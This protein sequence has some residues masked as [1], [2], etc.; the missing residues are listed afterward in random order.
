M[1]IKYPR[2]S[3]H[4]PIINEWIDRNMTELINQNEIEIFLEP[5]S[6]FVKQKTEFSISEDEINFDTSWKYSPKTFPSRIKALT[7]VLQSKHLYGNYSTIHYGGILT[8]KKV[9]PCRFS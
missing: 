2:D 4:I 9:E 7:K 6:G 1:K 3:V 5:A 8:V